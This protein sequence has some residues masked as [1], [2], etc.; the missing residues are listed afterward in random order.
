MRA[1]CMLLQPKQCISAV[2]AAENLVLSSPTTGTTQWLLSSEKAPLLMQ[3]SLLLCGFLCCSVSTIYFRAIRNIPQTT[4]A[5]AAAVVVAFHFGNKSAY[6]RTT[7]AVDANR[8]VSSL[9]GTA[10][11]NVA[12]VA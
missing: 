8:F 5:V 4:L 1:F 9:T 10:R 3:Q 11:E 7:L 2:T 12:H 6:K